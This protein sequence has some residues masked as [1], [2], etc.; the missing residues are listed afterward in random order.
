M[1]CSNIYGSELFSFFFLITCFDLLFNLCCL[2]RQS[3]IHTN[4]EASN[5][6]FFHYIMGSNMPFTEARIYH[7]IRS[8]KGIRITTD[9]MNTMIADITNGKSKSE[10]SVV[11]TPYKS[12]FYDKLEK[13]IKGATAKGAIIDIPP[14]FPDL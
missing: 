9:E 8:M 3:I 6:S 10:C 13:D 12:Q 1:I 14:D 2:Y 11:M 5:G 4:R 7:Y